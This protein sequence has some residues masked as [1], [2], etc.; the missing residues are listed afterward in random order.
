MSSLKIQT[1]FNIELEFEAPEF[2]RRMFAAILDLLLVFFYFRI[3]IAIFSSI[4]DDGFLTDD[5]QYNIHWSFLVSMLPV[6][7]Y[8]LICEIT[9]N[10]QSIGKKL[11]RIQV[12]NETGGRPSISQYLIRW[13]IRTS[14]YTILYIFVIAVFSGAVA[15]IGIF[16]AVLAPLLL[17]DIILVASTKKNQRLGDLLAHTILVKTNTKS[18]IEDTVFQEVADDYIPRF[19][20][21]MQLSDRDLNTIKGILSTSQT[22][23]DFDLASRAADKIKGHLKIE[24][25]LSPF[26]FLEI[27]LKDYNYLSTK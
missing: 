23:G 9:M 5:D 2:H 3:I 17:L 20:Q 19:P 18:N 11:M 13:L 15:A 4:Y 12:I 27:L 6:F 10:G 7:L 22:R 24:N 21:V 16:I 8:Q 25:S 26:E 14:D 1:N